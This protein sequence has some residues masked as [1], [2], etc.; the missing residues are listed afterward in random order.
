MVRFVDV[1]P[2]L[3]DKDTGRY[4]GSSIR[5]DEDGNI[6]GT[7]HVIENSHATRQAGYNGWGSSVSDNNTVRTGGG[8][9]TPEQLRSGVE[10]L[11]IRYTRMSGQYPFLILG[12]GY[13]ST[14]NQRRLL[15]KLYLWTGTNTYSTTLVP[16]QPG[17]SDDDGWSDPVDNC[18]FAA[19]SDQT[20]TDGD[21]DGDICDPD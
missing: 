10:D 1:P 15:P 20:D 21:G 5:E 4:V 17:D 7:R 13:Q 14:E 11:G 6:G 16:G 3:S 2:S 12:D 9:R 8:Q 18:P 19:N